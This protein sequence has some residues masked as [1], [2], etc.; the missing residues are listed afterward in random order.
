M[1]K[2]KLPPRQRMINLLYVILIAMLAINIS[3][4]TLDSYSI[5][6]EE[7]IE[8]TDRLMAYNRSLMDMLSVTEQHEGSVDAIRKMTEELLADMEDLQRE[9]VLRA[10]DVQD[11]EPGLIPN[12]KE[13]LN[14]V[15]Y[16]MLSVATNKASH[17]KDGL[18]ALR[19]SLCKLVDDEKTRE[20]ISSWLTMEDPGFGS[21]W[22]KETFSSMPAI[23]GVTYLNMLKER[24][25][26]ANAEAMKEIGRNFALLKDSVSVLKFP[27]GFSD[28]LA[29]ESETDTGNFVLVNNLRVSVDM[30][31]LM[32]LPV[33]NMEP[34]WANVLYADYSNVVDITSVGA[35]AD[36]LR[37]KAKGAKV[38]L[39]GK[40]CVIIPEAGSKTVV[41]SVSREHNGELKLIAK[42]TFHVSPLPTAEPYL[43]YVENGNVKQCGGN[44][45]LKKDMLLNVKNVCALI[46]DPVNEKISVTGFEVVLVKSDSGRVLASKC[47]GNRLSSEQLGL[48]ETAQ[49]GD[50][51]Y[52]TSLRAKR[53]GGPEMSLA[54][55]SVIV[56]S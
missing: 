11:G 36:D 23:A 16:T 38:T 55:I 48:L 20:M 40:K 22:E 26:L 37:L 19:D 29:D 28:M 2:Y 49:S 46:G 51:V 30:D 45:P 1:A 24:V 12:K 39:R 9:I 31:G 15:P 54:P 17:L 34:R 5:F 18:A 53:N 6:N 35:D 14:A 8:I 50:K 3:S 27:A 7:A 10:D 52:F 56:Y 25:L 44:V 13:E 42:K 32:D 21:S 43:E 33:V 47:S 4:D 41:V